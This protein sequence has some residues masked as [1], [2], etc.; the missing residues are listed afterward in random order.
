MV[1]V[2][3]VPI[4]VARAMPMSCPQQD[5]NNILFIHHIKRRAGIH[6]KIVDGK[7]AHFFPQK[8]CKNATLGRKNPDGAVTAKAIE[9]A[10]K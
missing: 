4:A 1:F 8:D 5:S 7:H 2:Y 3:F 9:C 6:R 10:K